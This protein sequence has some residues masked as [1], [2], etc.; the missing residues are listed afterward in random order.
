MCWSVLRA[1]LMMC[2]CWPR[3]VNQVNQVNQVVE[4]VELL[5]W[6]CLIFW[7]SGG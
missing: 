7:S 4:V 1:W 6:G 5:N 2:C 3:V